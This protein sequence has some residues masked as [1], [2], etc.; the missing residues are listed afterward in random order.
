STSSS[1]APG[2]V[3]EIGCE[4]ACSGTTAS[5]SSTTNQKPPKFGGGRDRA[6]G[7]SLRRRKGNRATHRAGLSLNLSGRA[8]LPLPGTDRL[9]LETVDTRLIGWQWRHFAGHIGHPVRRHVRLCVN[10]NGHRD[11]LFVGH[12]D[13]A[14]RQVGLARPGGLRLCEFKAII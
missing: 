12:M 14:N 1:V 4:R 3:A 2:A 7:M 10:E 5:A 9:D 8:E 11:G 13:E 6:P